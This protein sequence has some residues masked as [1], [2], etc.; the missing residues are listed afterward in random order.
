[1][2]QTLRN[3][4]SRGLGLFL[5]GVFLQGFNVGTGSVDLHG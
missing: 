4:L 3:K 1:M 5:P 2:K